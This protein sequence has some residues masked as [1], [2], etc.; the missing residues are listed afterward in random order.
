MTLNDHDIS[1]SPFLLP[2]SRS[3]VEAFEQGLPQ[4]LRRVDDALSAHPEINRLIGYHP[5]QTMRR[6]LHY[7]GQ[8]LA[9]LFAFGDCSLL[10]QNLSWLYRTY[11]AHQYA[12]GYFPLELKGWSD[13]VEKYLA[14]DV[15]REILPIFAWI[16]TRHGLLCSQQPGADR[17]VDEFTE[18]TWGVIRHKFQTALLAGN[19]QDCL[20]LADASI[21][22]CDT[23]LDF[24]QQVLCAA[25]SDIGRL[26]EEAEISPA[27]EHLATAIVGR[28]LASISLPKDRLTQERGTAVV[29]TVEHEQHQLGPLMVADILA[30]DGWNVHYSGGNLTQQD[31]LW[32]LKSLQPELLALSITLPCHLKQAEQTIA[33][34]RQEKSLGQLKVLAGG[35]ALAEHPDLARRIGADGLAGSFAMAREISRQWCADG[36]NKKT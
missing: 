10:L 25:M 19:H 17:A 27:Q 31:L 4:L 33:A 22:S 34:L 23:L 24:Y 11:H 9:M 3:T 14:A 21:C 26:W 13:A 2:V 35:Y 28:V 5:L 7:H 12:Y 20:T 30:G 8:F 29:A 16:E 36:T 32:K 15:V 6:N 1:D 18:E